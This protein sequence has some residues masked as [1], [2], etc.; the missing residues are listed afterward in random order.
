ML[1][2]LLI[3]IIAGLIGWINQDLLQQQLHWYVTVRPYVQTNITPYVLKPEVEHA[4]KP[5]QTFQECAKDCP[6]MVVLPA[7]EFLMGSPVGT[8]SLSEYPRHKVNIKAPFA[9]SKF[10]VTF[11]DW[12]ACVALRGCPS[13]S[14]NGYGKG[15]RPVINVSWNEAKQYVAWL[16]Q[17][18]GKTYRLLSEAEWEYAARGLTSAEAPHPAY[19]WGDTPSHEYANYGTD[20][21]GVFTGKQEVRDQ[22]INTAPVGQFPANA[23]GLHD[24]HGNVWEWVEDP[25]HDNYRGAPTDGSARLRD[26]DPGRRVRRGGAWDDNPRN[27][28]SA[29]RL[30][31]STFNRSVSLGFRVARTISPGTDERILH[32]TS[33]C[34]RQGLH[35]A[36]LQRLTLLTHYTL[37]GGIG[38]KLSEVGI[39][40]CG[41]IL[42]PLRTRHWRFIRHQVAGERVVGAPRTMPGRV[43]LRAVKCDMALPAF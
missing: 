19:P 26:G 27:L 18:T 40:K 22:W 21:S 43:S 38:P 17:H 31:V 9:V 12:E 37:F 28:R 41:P 15:N 10:E 34:P 1:T 24:M 6:Q 7:G 33:H 20:V 11:D 30:W 5:G 39:G 25:W 3:G 4:L 29:L 32:R 14:D 2:T 42:G 36:L 23:F 13:V 8:G 35:Q 16:S